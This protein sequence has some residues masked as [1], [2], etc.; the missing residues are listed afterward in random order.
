MELI[1]RKSE[2]VDA[3]VVEPSKMET[4]EMSESRS[5]WGRHLFSNVTLAS[6]K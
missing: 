5:D 4:L 2:A 6:F 3:S 1:Y